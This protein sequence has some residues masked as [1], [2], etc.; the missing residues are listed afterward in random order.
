[1]SRS[2]DQQ[3]LQKAFS[4]H[5]AGRLDD[6]AELYRRLIRKDP[7]SFHA[8]HYLGVIEASRSNYQHVKSLM[9]RS[10]AIEP[11]NIQFVENYATIL[12]QMG[13]YES[14]LETSKRGLRLS[15]VNIP[16]LY[17]GAISLLKLREFEASI[18]QFDRLLLLAPNHIAAINEQGSALAEIGQY[19]AALIRFEKVLRLQPQYAEA[20]VNRGNIF[21]ARKNYEDALAAYDKALALKPD[22]TDAWIGRGNI[23]RSL[24]QYDKAFAAYDAALASKTDLA[25]AWLGRGNV[26]FDLKRHPDALNAYDAALALKP[27]LAEAW[28][29]RG[30]VHFY[31]EHKYQDALAA[32]D[33]ALTLD[34]N[35]GEAWLGRGNV[36]GELKRYDEALTAIDRA[37]ALKPDLADAW[38]GRGNVVSERKQYQDAFAAYDKAVMLNPDID[39]AAGSRLHSKRHMCEWTNLEAETAQLLSSVRQ[40]RPA[41]VPFVLLGLPSSA[42]DQLQCAEHFVRSKPAFEPMCGDVY[43]HSRLRLAYLSSELR[44]H[45]VA[46]LTAGLFEHHDRSRFEVTAISFEAGQDSEFCRRIKSGFERFIDAHSQSD[47]EIADLIKKLEIDIMVDLNGFTRNGRLGVFARRPAP[48][49]VNYLG[50]AGTM[51]ADY[52]DYLVA[53]E[54]VIPRED[55]GFYSEKVAWLPDSFLP[56]DD[57]R[58]IAEQTPSRAELN[59]PGKAF[60]FCCFNQSFKIDPDIFDVWMRLLRQV[61]GSAL[62][63]KENN[64][65][66]THNLRLQ[67]EARGIGPERLIFAASVPLAAEHLARQRQADLFLDTLHYNA[68]TTANDALRVGLPVV[69]CIGSTFAGRVGASLLKAAGLPELI[70]TS[71]EDYEAIALRLAGDP[72]LLASV[73]ARLARN[74]QSCALFDTRRYTRH[75]EAAYA[76]MWQGHADGRTPESFSVQAVD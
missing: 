19:D 23:F 66:A 63:L 54:T 34:S 62:W 17:V 74:R 52:Y 2:G 22:L 3:Q 72:A 12:F 69:T 33:Q 6:A 45:A 31:F 42:A 70:T 14:A 15:D 64:P 10:L 32:Y 37:L 24:E 8:L 26:N 18:A 60:V 49:Q 56:N 25:G 73:K 20:H 29:G 27:D 75:I 16:L 59:L 39:Y 46:Y 30:N 38:L 35:L 44:E 1:M 65:E 50:Y 48:I 43:S 51:G 61:D 9:E 41:A 47:Q 71:L 21:G 13:D 5:Q 68:H 11:P 7:K 28:L 4:F 40:G 57:A 36:F 55:F 53:D 76:M 67:A 58:L